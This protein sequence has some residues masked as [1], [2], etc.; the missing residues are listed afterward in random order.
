MTPGAFI[1]C[2][3]NREQNCHCL[4]EIPLAGSGHGQAASAAAG[5]P[6]VSSAVY[7]LG[8][9]PV[10]DPGSG[11]TARSRP[12]GLPNDSRVKHKRKEARL[13]SGADRVC[14]QAVPGAGT[15]LISKSVMLG[16]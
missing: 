15:W 10:T 2:I 12:P 8:H 4:Q 13:G 9:D 11:V 14:L 5:H 1:L 6:P 3:W 16:G 7:E